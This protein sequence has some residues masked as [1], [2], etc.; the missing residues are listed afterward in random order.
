MSVTT[1]LP[2][3]KSINIDA[4]ANEYIIH[5]LKFLV[6]WRVMRLE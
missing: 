5:I 3:N 6:V 1:V 4:L 2:L